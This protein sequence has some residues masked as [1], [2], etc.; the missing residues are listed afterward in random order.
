MRLFLDLSSNQLTGVVPASLARFTDVTIYLRNNLFE[1]IHPNVCK[2][3]SWNGGD[4]DAYGCD[5]IMCPVKSYSVTGR[6]S[7]SGTPCLRCSKSMYFGT[8]PECAVH[9][10][11]SFASYLSLKAL[12]VMTFGLSLG[13]LLLC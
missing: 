7:K 3:P 4:V 1:G 13:H 5:G 12:L 11:V 8:A 6:A 9:P 10:T 2:Q